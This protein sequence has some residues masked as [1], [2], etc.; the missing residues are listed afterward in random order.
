MSIIHTL[1][2]ALGLIAGGLAAVTGSSERPLSAEEVSA[3]QLATWLQR[4][5]PRIHLLD[6]RSAERYAQQRLPGARQSASL[7]ELKLAPDEIL[8]VYAAQQLDAA[9]SHALQQ[10]FGGQYRQLR[11]GAQAW[12]NEVLFPVIRSDATPSQRSAFAA[13]A[14]LS[15]YFGGSPRVLQPGASSAHQRSRRGC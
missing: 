6:L 3:S 13:R 11:G 5:Q 9:Q 15:R 12:S 4:R 14:K 10:R 7:A 2:A 1:L 8:V